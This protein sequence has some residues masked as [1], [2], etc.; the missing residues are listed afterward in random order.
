MSISS[1]RRRPIG[2]RIAANIF[3]IVWLILAA[4]PFFWTLWGS[5]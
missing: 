4:F 2:L 3:V 5:F 1:A